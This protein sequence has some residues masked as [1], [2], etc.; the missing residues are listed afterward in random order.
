MIDVVIH[1]VDEVKLRCFLFKL[2][3]NFQTDDKTR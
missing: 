3:G 1:D 2:M